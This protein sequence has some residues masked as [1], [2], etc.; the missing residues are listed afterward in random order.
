LDGAGRRGLVNLRIPALA[1]GMFGGIAGHAATPPT[2][3]D[4]ASRP[5]VEDLSISPDGRYLALIHTRDGKAV[6]VVSDRKASKGQVMRPVLSEPEH[7][8]MTWC[9]WATNTRL[10]CGFIGMI[11]DRSVYGVTRLAAVDADGKNMRVL[12]QNS[13]EAQGQ[14]QDR[15]VNWHPGPPDTVLIEADEGLD[16]SQMSPG[17]QIIGNV[18]THGLPAVFELN[19]VTGRL[20]LRQHARDPIRHWIT[21]R[22]GQVRVGWGFVGTTI[23]YWAHPEGES[24]WRRLTKFEVFSRENHFEPTAISEADPNLAYAFGPSE[25]RKAKLGSASL[26]AV[27]SK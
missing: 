22:Q 9:R 14:R 27:G 4:F 18:G 19:I 13:V 17:V 3:E 20:R 15:I 16:A 6:A 1:V 21:D 8:R 7:F 2:I 12:I 24:N 23:S 26:I 5:Q 11:H 25:G 10:M